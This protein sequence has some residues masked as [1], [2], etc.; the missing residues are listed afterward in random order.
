MG[1]VDAFRLSH[2]PHLGHD[3]QTC[4]HSSKGGSIAGSCPGSRIAT[5]QSVVYSEGLSKGKDRGCLAHGLEAPLRTGQS[6][7]VES[8]M[9]NDGDS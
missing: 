4:S 2:R 9:R 1:G 3:R 7:L 5:T 8:S 6:A